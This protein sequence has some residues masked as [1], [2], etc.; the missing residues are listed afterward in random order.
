MEILPGRG[1]EAV[2]VGEARSV[3]E[4]RLG[5]PHHGPGD[6]PAVYTVTSPLIVVHYDAEGRVELVETGYGGAEAGAEAEVWFDGVQL[7][8][9]FMD[10]VVSDLGA[11]GH[12]GEPFD[13]GHQFR[14][15]FA[16]FSTGSLWA[17]ELDPDAG[18]DDRRRV[19]DGV[20]VAPY[21]YFAGE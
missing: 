16:V 13:V 18:E 10:D 7:T 21:A 20:S 8:Y 4:G 19:S 6:N 12:V 17:R 15:G 5:V 11:L 9:R 14:A 1:I 3:V 2:K